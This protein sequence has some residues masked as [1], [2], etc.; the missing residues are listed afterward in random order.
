MNTQSH[1]IKITTYTESDYEEVWALHRRTVSENEGYVKN[2]LF[3]SDFQNISET[4]EVF[5][6][7][8][9]DNKIVGIVGLKRIDPLTLEVKR[10]QVSSTHQGKGLGKMLMGKAFEYGRA[11]KT[12]SLRLDVSSP[13]TRARNMYLSM[14]FEITHIQENVV[15]PDKE[16]FVSTYMRKAL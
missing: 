6:V 11:S 14:G 12:N 3:H 16:K 1:A 2:L 5:F 15:G 7:A 4:Y 8:R 10:L 13:Q 9:D